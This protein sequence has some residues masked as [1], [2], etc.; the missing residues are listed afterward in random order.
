MT[1]PPAR[2]PKP[3]LA[4]PR[5]AAPAGRLRRLRLAELPE[6][7]VALARFLIGTAIVSDSADGRTAARIVETEAY[8]PNDAACHAFRGETVRNRTLFRRRGLAYV[9][10]IY[11]NH[12]C[13]NVSSEVEGVGAGVLLRAAE[14]LVGLELMRSRRPGSP[15]RD[16]LRGPGRLAAALGVG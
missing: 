4:S 14:P 12:F 8:L 13:V 6:D 16:L 5:E 11:G 15:E 10:F 1:S 3:P 7:T 9:Y 2:A